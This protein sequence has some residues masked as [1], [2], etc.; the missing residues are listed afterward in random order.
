[1]TF[2]VPNFLLEVSE[3]NCLFG[4]RS[5]S[6][7]D[8]TEYPNTRFLWLVIS[9]CFI[10]WQILLTGVCNSNEVFFC[11]GFFG[12]WK[13]RAFATTL[14]FGTAMVVAF[15]FLTLRN[16]FRFWGYFLFLGV[17]KALTTTEDCFTSGF[18]VEPFTLASVI[19]WEN[20]EITANLDNLDFEGFAG[21]ERGHLIVVLE[22]QTNKLSYWKPICIN[23]KIN[24][25]SRLF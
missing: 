4:S 6:L 10:P 14:L 18:G 13:T 2:R 20:E 9:S 11:L 24:T 7:D 1:M 17:V 12:E 21:A 23:T 15:G 22:D 16:E 8:L 25:G 3:G 19:F 5:V